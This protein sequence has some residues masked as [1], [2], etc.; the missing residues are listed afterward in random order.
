MENNQNNLGYFPYM[1]VCDGF[2]GTEL[3][4]DFTLP[5]YK[6]EIRKLISTKVNVLPPKKYIGNDSATLEGEITCKLIYVGADSGLYSA[7][8]SDT[9]KIEIPFEFNSHS[10]NTD[11][12]SLVTICYDDGTSTRVLGPRKVNLRSKIACRALAFSSSLYAPSHIGVGNPSSVENRILSTPAL[13]ISSCESDMITLNDTISL[14]PDID[15]MRIVDL[16]SSTMINECSVKNGFVNIKGDLLLK[17][18]YC[19]DAE[20]AQALT[21]TRKL[22]FSQ[23][24][25]CRGAQDGAE[26]SAYASIIDENINLDESSINT[27]VIIKLFAFTQHNE[28]VS[29]I[30]DAFS[31]ECETKTKLEDVYAPIALKNLCGHLTQNDILSSAELKID[32]DARM[33]DCQSNVKI[34][35][36]KLENNKFTLLGKTELNL[37]YYHDGEYGSKLHTLPLK[38]ELDN[39]AHTDG[40]EIVCSLRADCISTRAR[41]DGERI[42]V[43]Q[44]LQ[45]CILL[46]AKKKL[47]LLERLEFGE[48]LARKSADITLCYPSKDATLWDVSKRY[49]KSPNKIRAK[50]S[51]SGDDIS[52]KRYIIV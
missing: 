12:L 6:S 15:S 30:C 8:L 10:L 43:D 26:C 48:K 41:S 36:C 42:F 5:D 32:P 20:S 34:E 45:F 14:D 11:D 25:E 13:H 22:P 50:N 51:I 28:D 46:Q 49:C 2:F 39:R 23:S 40:G 18:L 21:M 24:I 29:Y 3:N 4:A 7:N 16:H 38:Y 9:Y 27:E 19:N 47:C 1:P 35:S 52:K 44:E 37:I 33:I 17:L 31:T